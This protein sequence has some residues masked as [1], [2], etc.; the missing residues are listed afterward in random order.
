MKVMRTLRESGVYPLCMI[1]GSAAAD[2]P[3]SPSRKEGGLKCTHEGCDFVATRM[4]V[5][6]KHLRT[7]IAKAEAAETLLSLKG[8]SKRPREEGSEEGSEEGEPPSSKRPRKDGSEEGEPPSSQII[9][10]TS[11]GKKSK[12]KSS[13]NKIKRSKRRRSSK[14][15]LK[16]KR[17]R[18]SKH[19]LKSKRRSRNK[20]IRRHK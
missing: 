16:S 13:K 14:H 6:R 4:G 2:V 9:P 19:S 8:S 15:A 7:H 3:T 12:R 18:S 11:D 10:G 17:R 5:L 20:H 1:E